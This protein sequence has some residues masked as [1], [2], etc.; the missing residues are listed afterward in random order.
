M[1]CHNAN[2]V[3]IWQILTN[4]K[5]ISGDSSTGLYTRH[6]C[7]PESWNKKALTLS[8]CTGNALEPGTVLYALVAAGP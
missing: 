1:P 2:A 6:R 8:K 3:S 5:L 7:L 4:R